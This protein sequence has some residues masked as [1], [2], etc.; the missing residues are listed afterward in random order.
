[1]RRPGRTLRRSA[2]QAPADAPQLKILVAGRGRLPHR[3]DAAARRRSTPPDDV[4]RRDV[5]RRRPP[6]LR[7]DRAAVR[8]RVGR[9]ARR[10]PTH[11]V[12]V[13]A[14][15]TGGARIV[16]TVRT[17]SV[18][19]VERVD[20]DVV[21]VTVT[22]ADGHGKFVRN[23]PQSAFHVFEDGQPQTI[24]HFASEDVPLELIAAIDITGSMAP[25]M[26]KL[27]KAVKEFLGDVPP[28]DQVTLL[29]F[30]D[31]IFTLTRKAT[32]P[33][34]R[35]KAVDRLAPWGSTALYDVLL[36]GVEMLGPADRAQG[37]GRLHRR[38]G[39]G[40]PRDDQ[41]RR[42]PAAVERRDA[43]H[44]RPGPR[45]DDGAAEEDHGAA[46]GADRRP[47]AVHRQHRRAA[48]RLRRSARRAVEPVPARLPVRPTPSATMRGGRSRWRSTATTRCAR[49]R[50]I[51]HWRANDEPRSE[52]TAETAKIA[53]KTS[54]WFLLCG[55]CVLP[56]FFCRRRRSSRRRSRASSRRSRSPRS[57]SR[58]STTRASRSPTLTPADFAVR[59]DGNARR[60]VTAEWVPLGGE[61]GARAAAAAR[62]L[63]APTKARP[64]AG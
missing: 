39:S 4:D 56:G 6:G 53:E 19:Y 61:A 46:V 63:H 1:M 60:V 23:I 27:K 24:T 49:G 59:I 62:G 42:A 11:Q 43:L 32:D 30:N 22:V 55:L 14:T 26:P 50:D 33:A 15:V 8:V 13:V 21:Q 3:R 48:R 2:A 31:S 10:S 5:L 45:R 9:R 37:A 28:Q 54:S 58:S 20:V 29:G 44:D 25:A 16:Q 64:A 51:A 47:R 36:R 12:R 18:G 35:I 41:R 38:R 40:Q 52:E 57:T 17:K 34:E 7:A